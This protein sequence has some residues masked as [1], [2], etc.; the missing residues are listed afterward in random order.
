MQSD[1]LAA[2]AAP[3]ATVRVQAQ[4][5]AA[6]ASASVLDS[7]NGL[8]P[9]WEHTGVLHNKGTVQL[10]Y[11][12]A[13]VGLGYVQLSTQPFL[14]LYGTLN[15]QAK[16]ALLDRQRLKVA[17]VAGVYRIATNAQ[18]RMFG[19]LNAS[20]IVNPYGP[21]YV[22]PLALA[23]SLSL[24][25]RWAVHWASTLLLT[26]GNEQRHISGGQAF[27]FEALANRHWR[28]RMHVGV[29]GLHVQGQGHA[30]LSFA[31]RGDVLRLEAGAGRR[32]TFSG[33][34]STFVMFDGAMVF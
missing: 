34:Q 33:E 23:K 29:E 12:Q 4:P 3:E 2:Q 27:L 30:A 15:L 5:Q 24:S 10:G 17:V 16:V 8:Y 9:L 1:V 22:A 14:D 21:L 26:S 11:Q 6:P 13:Q 7:V 19:N 25:H 32:I 20:G 28:A 31:Y 18:S